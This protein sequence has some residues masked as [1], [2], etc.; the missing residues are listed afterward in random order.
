M[1]MK[2]KIRSVS[3]L[4]RPLSVFFALLTSAICLLTSGGFAATVPGNLTD[5]SLQALNTKITFSPTNDVLL[6][7]TGLSAGPPRTIDVANGQFSIV[8]DAG[9][10]T[11]SLPLITYRRPFKISVFATN[12]TVNITNLLSPARTYTYTNNFVPPLHVNAPRVISWSTNGQTSL[13]DGP[14]TLPA[15]SLSARSILRFEAFGSFS[16][17]AGNAPLATIRLKLGATT[18]VVQSNT[19]GTANWHLSGTITIRSTGSS[20]V[21]AATLALTQDDNSPA[22]FSIGSQTAPIS[23]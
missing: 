11:V 14:V 8:L 20:G 6:N 12:G 5:I 13:L 4:C 1:H 9:D 22:P 23:T 19:V 2:S 18:I 3:V 17:P 7:D 15:A 21:A 10:Y 16:D